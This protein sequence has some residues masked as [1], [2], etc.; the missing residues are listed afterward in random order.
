MYYSKLSNAFNE[1]SGRNI[2]QKFPAELRFLQI[3]IEYEI[4]GAFASDPVP[5]ASIISGDGATP[6]ALVTVTTN[7]PHEFT[8]GT[9][10]R[11]VCN[12]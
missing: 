3:R 11:C 9:P 5:V 4:V 7:Q 1:S 6:S 8:V 10:I 2:D 12:T